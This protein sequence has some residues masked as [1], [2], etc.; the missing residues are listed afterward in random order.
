MIAY[1]YISLDSGI[2][3]PFLHTWTAFPCCMCVPLDEFCFVLIEV[4]LVCYIV[5][6]VYSKVVEFI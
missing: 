4:L 1:T 5:F 2:Q 3:L 6:P